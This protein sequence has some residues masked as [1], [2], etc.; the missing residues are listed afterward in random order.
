MKLEQTMQAT[1]ADIGAC[2]GAGRCLECDDDRC[3]DD[4]AGDK[5]RNALAQQ[6]RKVFEG[7]AKFAPED[8]GMARVAEFE[9]AVTGT[10]KLNGEDAPP[11]LFVRLFSWDEARQHHPVWVMEG[12]RVRVTVEV[13]D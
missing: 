13:I 5:A 2:D 1:L 4:C 3:A 6:D 7:V 8:D 10:I 12:K 9:S 11:H